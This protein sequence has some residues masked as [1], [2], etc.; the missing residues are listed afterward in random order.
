MQGLGLIQGW[1]LIFGFRAYSHSGFRCHS[2]LGF[3]FRVE[4]FRVQG[5][6]VQ[7]GIRFSL[8]NVSIYMYTCSTISRACCLP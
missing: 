7:G 2:I 8:K 5:H 3:G 4:G 6:L 1:G